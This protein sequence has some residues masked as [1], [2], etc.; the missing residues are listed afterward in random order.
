MIRCC[1]LWV[2][3]KWKRANQWIRPNSVLKRYKPHFIDLSSILLLIVELYRVWFLDT[4]CLRPYAITISD[5][6]DTKSNIAYDFYIVLFTYLNDCIAFMFKLL[7]NCRL[8]LDY[9]RLTC[10]CWQK[11]SIIQSLFLTRNLSTSLKY[12]NI[13][14]NF[15][16]KHKLGRIFLLPYVSYWLCRK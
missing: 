8:L 6:I 9:Y 2:I 7:F 5:D 3:K 11:T 14:W 10:I 15:L 16:F 13:L 4:I 1:Q 12:A